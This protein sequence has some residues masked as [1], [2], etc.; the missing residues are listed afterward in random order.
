MKTH[1]SRVVST[2]TVTQQIPAGLRFAQLAVET[3]PRRDFPLRRLMAVDGVSQAIDVITNHF[4][5]RRLSAISRQQN[6]ALFVRL[7]LINRICWGH[8]A[9]FPGK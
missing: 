2:V 6:G 5:E 1:Q 7:L 4:G 8:G 3:Q 9:A